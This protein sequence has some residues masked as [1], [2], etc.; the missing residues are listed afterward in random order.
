MKNIEVFDEQLFNSYCLGCCISLVVLI[1]V[2]RRFYESK[3]LGIEVLVILSVWGKI[4]GSLE[5]LELKIAEEKLEKIPFD[6]PGSPRLP[7]LLRAGF[8]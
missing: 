7:V 4:Y 6:N 2:F 1:R 8:V 5:G 3:L